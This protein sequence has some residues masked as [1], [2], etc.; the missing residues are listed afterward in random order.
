M[1][2]LKQTRRLLVGVL[3]CCLPALFLVPA[4]AESIDD[5]MVSFETM[6]CDGQ[7]GMGLIRITEIHRINPH[8]C[9]DGTAMAQLLTKSE[10]GSGPGGLFNI[11]PTEV[12]VIREEVKAWQAAKRQ[13]LLNTDRL[14]IN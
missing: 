12:K 13:Q 5:Y 6:D 11:S 10:N 8:K 7:I 1:D 2:G 9:P 14:I 4:N 3:I